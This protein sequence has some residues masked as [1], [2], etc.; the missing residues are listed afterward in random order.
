VQILVTVAVLLSAPPSGGAA[1]RRAEATAAVIAAEEAR[2]VDVVVDPGALLE[3][4]WMSEKRLA[5]FGEAARLVDDG[6]RKLA[7]VELDAAEQAFARAEALYE[8]HEALPGVRS[9]WAEA[10]KWRGVALYELKRRE[11]A[12]RAF[13][14]AK[15]LDAATELT[16][17]MVRPEVVRAFAAAP[18]A[19]EK[20]PERAVAEAPASVVE[21]MAAL[22]VD[23]TIEV[24]IA[25]D[26]GQLLY[27]AT[28]REAG[29]MTDV[30]TARAADELVQKLSGAPCRG[31]AEVRVAE[32]P[33]IAH[34]RPAPLLTTKVAPGGER[35]PSVWRKPWLWVGVVGAVAVGV[36][37][38]ASLWPRDPSYSATADFHSFAL[39][40]R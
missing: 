23:A 18:V 31:G 17:A 7:R 40:Q 6:R 9:S 15:G 27:A 39:G 19:V 13:A 5:F 32:A 2:G 36:V 21:R 16:E 3:R 10:A 8:G 37:L 12:V 25:I 29:C 28:R 30:V 24:A 35:R 34:P 4:G 38:G 14:R 26:G 33:A 1:A 22:G 20:A 11:D